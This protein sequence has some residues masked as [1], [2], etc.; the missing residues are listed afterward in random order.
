MFAQIFAELA[1]ES[2]ATDTKMIDPTQLKAHRATAGLAQLGGREFGPVGQIP[3]IR[4]AE[5]RIGKIKGGL[6]AKL[7]VLCDEKCKS[8]ILLINDG[9]NRDEN[10][11][12]YTFYARP[13]AA[14][15][16]V[17]DRSN[18]ADWPREARAEQKIEPCILLRSNRDEDFPNGKALYIRRNLIE[19]SFRRLKDWRRIS[20]Q[21][22]HCA[23]T[24]MYV[25]C[26]AINVIFW[27]RVLFLNRHHRV[28]LKSRSKGT[29]IP[30]RLPNS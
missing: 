17:A 3:P 22:D 25:I 2:V 14:R 11:V 20:I 5:S 9:M 23:Q 24:F 26:I 27:L 6:N 13:P 30:D 21:F 10:G 7:R 16:Y 28:T 8:L 4:G 1:S 19:R 15:I 12:N 29:L 18:D